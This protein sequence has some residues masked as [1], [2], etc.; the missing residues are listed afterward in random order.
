MDQHSK[1]IVAALVIAGVVVVACILLAL[2]AGALSWRLPGTSVPHMRGDRMEGLCPW[3]GGTEGRTLW[4]SVA[5][6]AM[7]LLAVVLP[8][9]VIALMIVGGIWLVRSAQSPP[10]AREGALVCPSCG[11]KVEAG[12]KT[13]PNCDQKLTG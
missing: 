5:A 13:C 10:S 2:L 4:G 7:V 1:W 11:E 12:W 3:C 9:G 6:V 8:L